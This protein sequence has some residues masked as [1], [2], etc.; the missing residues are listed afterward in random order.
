MC[1]CEGGSLT[2]NRC[3]Y[4]C[5]YRCLSAVLFPI[6]WHHSISIYLAL[7]DCNSTANS[8]SYSPI[9]FSSNSLNRTENSYV[10]GSTPPLATTICK[11]L[12]LIISFVINKY[13]IGSNS[14][15]NTKKQI[16]SR[17]RACV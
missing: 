8:N 15:F 3:L 4:R 16:A 2:N 9:S 1:A 10:G 13:I 12:Q 14:I 6:N 7:K 5:P 11:D 17:T